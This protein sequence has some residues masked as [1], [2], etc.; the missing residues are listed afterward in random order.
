[1]DTLRFALALEGEGMD[2]KHASI[3]AHEMYAL[4]AHS[5]LGGKYREID[6]GDF[7]ALSAKADKVRKEKAERAE[8][9]RIFN[10]EVRRDR[11]AREAQ[12]TADAATQESIRETNAYLKVRLELNQEQKR[13]DFLLENG[14]PMLG[15][16]ENVYCYRGWEHLGW[17]KTQREAID[18]A[19]K[20]PPK[21]EQS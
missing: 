7:D 18:V 5:V 19:I 21:G 14:L 4:Y 8:K 2:P 15:F 13:L 1:M 16:E 10:E 9:L 17:F 20:Y 12:A 11:E 3:I 6:Y